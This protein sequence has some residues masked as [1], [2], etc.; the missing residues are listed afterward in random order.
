MHEIDCRIVGERFGECW[1]PCR[2]Y[3]GSVQSMLGKL[4][5]L[6]GSKSKG[7]VDF[8][9]SCSSSLCLRCKFTDLNMNGEY[10]FR[11]LGKNK[12]SILDGC[13][14]YS[15]YMSELSSIWKCWILM[16]GKHHSL[17]IICAVHFLQTLKRSIMG[18][19]GCFF[20]CNMDKFTEMKNFIDIGSVS[21][22]V[23][24]I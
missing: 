7:W 19:I 16:N 17:K 22:M 8:S 4:S 18:H 21:N 10:L 24:S 5:K 14:S 11:P 23:P 2:L 13:W 9:S 3:T 6:F 1:C 15:Y 12:F 20:S